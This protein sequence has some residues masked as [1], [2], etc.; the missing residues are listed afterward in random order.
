YN[1]V[2]SSLLL[3]VPISGTNGQSSYTV[4]YGAMKNTGWEV[5]LSSRNVMKN[6]ED[7]FSWQTD[8]NISTLKNEIT[9]L[10]SPLTSSTYK[11]DVGDNYYTFYLPAYAGVDP[12]TG[13]AHW[14]ASDD[15]GQTTNKYDN[16]ARIKEGSA[17]PDF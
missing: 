7:G 15:K 5:S 12:Q 17:L 14:Y 1:R 2:T 4:N 11:R 16:A 6:S 3:E 10:P 8:F 9:V 13:E